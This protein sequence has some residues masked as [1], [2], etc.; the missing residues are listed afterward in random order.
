VD[1]KPNGNIELRLLL[2]QRTNTNKKQKY[3]VTI[4]HDHRYRQS[5]SNEKH[6]IKVHRELKPVPT[7]A[8]S[9]SSYVMKDAGYIVIRD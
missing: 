2:S 8:L 6:D 1:A 9:I 5:T 4:D 3:Q 7:K